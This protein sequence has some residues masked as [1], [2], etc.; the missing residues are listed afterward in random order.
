MKRYLIVG[1]AG[2]IGSHLA[3]TLVRLG[4]QVHVMVRET[5]DRDRL[6]DVEGEVTIHLGDVEDLGSLHQVYAAARPDVVFHLACA[7][8]KTRKIAMFDSARRALKDVDGLLNVLAAAEHATRPPA[9]F[10][11]AGT[12][13]E[14]GRG[15]HPYVEHQRERPVSAHAVGMITAT[16]L[17]DVLQTE[18]S[19][20]IIT[21]RLAIV[22]GPGQSRRF[23]VPQLVENCLIG[24]TTRVR[25]PDEGRDLIH[26]NDVTQALA[27]L[28]EKPP[29]SNRTINIATGSATTM[30]DVAEIVKRHAKSPKETVAFGSGTSPN[31]VRDGSGSPDLMQEL[32][33]WRAQ[34]SLDEGLRELVHSQLAVD[35]RPNGGV[36]G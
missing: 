2:F 36:L 14:Y 5:T 6:S 34:V 15:T 22:Y 32:Y 30:R 26:V 21:A 1:G 18:L 20:P 12:L 19:F 35:H 8:K 31:G 33:G 24:Q 23:L 28:S 10:I 13:A 27:L 16:H 3:R 11:R 29:V 9:L 17:S 4:K 25:Y 7:T